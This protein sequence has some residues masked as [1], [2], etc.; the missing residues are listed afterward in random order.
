MKKWF[1][2]EGGMPAYKVHFACENFEKPEPTTVMVD[3]GHSMPA[4]LCHCKLADKTWLMPSVGL[5]D[6][7]D[8]CLLS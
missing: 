7:E 5:E 1:D 2:V 3:E 6:E 8:K 4:G